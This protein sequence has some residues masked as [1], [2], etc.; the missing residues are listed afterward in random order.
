MPG[1]ADHIS[2]RAVAPTWLLLLP[3]PLLALACENT[4]TPVYVG[5]TKGST[6]TA[7]PTGTAD[8]PYTPPQVT[9]KISQVKM[10]WKDRQQTFTIT[11]TNNGDKQEI[12]H[13]V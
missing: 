8:K 7:P 2:S 6:G 13:A 5:K 11:L 10:N 1:A 12:I 4:P 3:L 9:A